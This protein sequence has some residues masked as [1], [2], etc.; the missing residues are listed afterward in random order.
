MLKLYFKGIGM[1][2]GLMFGAGVFA[3]PYVF[4]RA[5]IFWGVFHFSVVFVILLFLYFLYS[6]IAYFTKGKH[7][8]TGY[9]DLFLGETSKKIAFF[10]TVGSYYGSML[11]YGLLGGFFLTN[12]LEPLGGVDRFKASLLFFVLGA[13]LV[14]LKLGKIAEVNFYL[15]VPLFGF[16]IYLLFAA[17]PE[18]RVEN[19]FSN[20]SFSFGDNWFLPYG[21]WLFSLG[22]FAALPEVRDFFEKSRLKD[23]RKVIV[24]SLILSAVFY[25]IFILAVWGASNNSTTPDALSGLVAILGRKALVVGSLVGFLSVFT[26]YLAISADLKS[27]F[28]YDYNFKRGISWFMTVLPPVILFMLGVSDFTSVIGIIGALG[29]GVTGIFIIAMSNSFRRK[30]S[31][32]ESDEF[33]R[34]T[35]GHYMKANRL[36]KLIIVVAILAGVV[37]E[38]WSIFS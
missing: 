5:G 6:E 1:I 37:Y 30:I 17:L 32:K 2:V 12:I 4:S 36:P 18:I 11:V 29:L 8:F 3:L 28:R 9:V 15:T 31:N 22:G 19:L 21:V 26:S 14:F 33:L 13:I 38:L 23:F 7:R 24:I 16:V 35:Q 20:I 25:F 34:P 27:I 10:T